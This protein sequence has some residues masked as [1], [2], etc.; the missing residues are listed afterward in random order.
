MKNIMK[1]ENVKDESTFETEKEE[2]ILRLERR[3]NSNWQCKNSQCKRIISK[4]SGKLSSVKSLIH[5]DWDQ[6]RWTAPVASNRLGDGSM[7]NKYYAKCK[8]QDTPE[9]AE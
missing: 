1:E 5:G 3:N 9:V 8:S 7:R 6:N 2:K 4:D